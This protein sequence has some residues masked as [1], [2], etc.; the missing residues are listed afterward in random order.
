MLRW[1]AVC[2]QGPAGSI[3]TVDPWWDWLLHDL[4]GFYK[5]FFDSIDELNLFVF[6]VLVARKESSLQSWRRCLDKDLSSRPYRWLR[7]DLV[8]PAPCLVCPPH[9][10][11]VSGSGPSRPR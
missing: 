8:P 11:W 1:A 2:R 7:P 3:K 4:H 10:G 5:W 6:R 9:L